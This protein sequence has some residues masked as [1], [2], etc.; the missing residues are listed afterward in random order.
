MD[1]H[2][3]TTNEPATPE[4]ALAV[5]KDMHRQQC[6]YESEADPSAVLSFNTTVAEW[7]DAC[8]LVRWREL[9]R[10]YNHL[11]GMSCSDDEWHAVLEPAGQRRLADVCR[12]VAT[13]A[14]RPSIRPTRLLGRKCAPAGGR[15]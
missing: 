13:R 7:R 12:L 8:D 11:F 9:G 5:L 10:A 3:S 6:Q 15:G 1:L 4:F 14:V 2:Y